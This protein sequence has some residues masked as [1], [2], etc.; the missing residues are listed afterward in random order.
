MKVIVTKAVS[1]SA[2]LS[3]LLGKL[4]RVFRAACASLRRGIEL[5]GEKY[6]NGM[7]PPL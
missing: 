5:S 2:L 3:S 4:R 6:M 7:I 1:S